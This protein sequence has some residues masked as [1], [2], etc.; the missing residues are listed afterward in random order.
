[1][2]FQE[3]YSVLKIIDTEIFS[4]ESALWYIRAKRRR[5]HALFLSIDWKNILI[6]VELEMIS[7]SFLVNVGITEGGG[8]EG[9]AQAMR[10]NLNFLALDESTSI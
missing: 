1:M 9:E 5:I 7:V 4:L 2:L 3:F 10:N 8:G 6:L